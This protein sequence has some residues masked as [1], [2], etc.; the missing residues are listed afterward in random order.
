MC[1]DSLLAA[2]F[3][4]TFVWACV[5]SNWKE[6]WKYCLRKHVKVPVENSNHDQRRKKCKSNVEQQ[7]RNITFHKLIT[8]FTTFLWKDSDVDIRNSLKIEVS[9]WRG[10]Q[11]MRQLDGIIDSMDM[12][13]NKLRE[14]VKEREAWRAAVHGVA[15]SPTPLSNWTTITKIHFRQH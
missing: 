11:R 14:M 1:F 15:K 3:I 6:Q 13:L 2:A 10:R 12:S 7:F 5:P 8:S 4:C 9:R